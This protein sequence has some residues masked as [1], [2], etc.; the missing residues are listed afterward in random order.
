MDEPGGV[1]DAWPGEGSRRVQSD[2]AR[3]QSPA[4]A[5]Y[6]R[7]RG[8]DGRGGSLKGACRR[9][10]AASIG[11]I[12]ESRDPEPRL[13]KIGSAARQDLVEHLSQLGSPTS[14][15]QRVFARSARI[16]HQSGTLKCKGFSGALMRCIS[17]P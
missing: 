9:D 8:T 16:L 6:C 2:G 13:S 10:F 3:L 14:L 5:Q 15:P 7:L 11:M 1:S 12:T 4:G 17:K